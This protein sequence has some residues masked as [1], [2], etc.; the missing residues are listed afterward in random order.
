MKYNLLA[1]LILLLLLSNDYLIVA[2]R[3]NDDLSIVGS[4]NVSFKDLHAKY[5][6]IKVSVK[7][8]TPLSGK[9]ML[10]L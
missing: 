10:F 1:A 9:T 4:Y 6:Q 8:Q 5:P 3:D 7:F 2:A